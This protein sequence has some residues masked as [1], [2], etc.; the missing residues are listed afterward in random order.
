MAI[1]KLTSEEVN[2][3]LIE[4][5]NRGYF[6]S[7]YTKKL[8][9]FSQE[10]FP[11]IYLGTE[12]DER[13][14]R[15]AKLLR[16]DP[17]A[18]VEYFFQNELYLHP[19]YF[20]VAEKFPNLTNDPKPYRHSNL[21]VFPKKLSTDPKYEKA[22]EHAGTKFLFDDVESFVQ[23]LDTAIKLFQK[24]EAKLYED[25]PTKKPRKL[26]KIS[27]SLSSAA[28]V[29]GASSS[30]SSENNKA[31]IGES[32]NPNPN[33]D[34]VTSVVEGGKKKQFTYIYERNASL[35]KQAL[36]KFGYKCAACGF[37]FES[38]YGPELGDNFIEVHHIIP[39]SDGER[40]NDYTNLRP[41][42]SNCHRMIH[43]LY[44]ELEPKDYEHAIEILATK[45][46]RG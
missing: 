26:A 27:K 16:I 12:N 1:R 36:K 20:N 37:S 6:R 28:S 46:K 11:T 35:R 19:D 24:A 14:E 25:I 2:R 33:S 21:N 5:E 4:L 23:L 10:G 38:F 29:S 8:N 3:V 30:E 34:Y 43:R 42:C 13:T 39:V 40:E 7:N 22:E 31:S 9:E 15:Y 41:I 45:I 44:R 18:E 32:L 17:D